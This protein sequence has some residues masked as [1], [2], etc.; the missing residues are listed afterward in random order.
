[1]G[2]GGA[3]SADASMGLGGEH[4]EVE[5]GC[6]Q[7]QVED[8]REARSAAR[9]WQGPHGKAPAERQCTE[10]AA[11]EICIWAQRSVHQCFPCARGERQSRGSSRPAAGRRGA[12]GAL[13]SQGCGRGRDAGSARAFLGG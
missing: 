12:R 8:H 3:T 2:G 7:Q 5:H 1:M 6:K 10:P 9:L 11:A 4:V 13:S